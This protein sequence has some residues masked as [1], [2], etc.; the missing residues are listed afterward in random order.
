MNKEKENNINQLSNL[1]INSIAKNRLDRVQK[2]LKLVAF[3]LFI[4]SIYFFGRLAIY[5]FN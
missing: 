2:W 1:E 4:P 3:G 5:L